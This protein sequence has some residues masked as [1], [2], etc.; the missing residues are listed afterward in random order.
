MALNMCEMETNREGTQSDS[1]RMLLAQLNRF[2][3]D[4]WSSLG[5]GGQH[6]G[7]K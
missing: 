3:E 6:R 5:R 1:T 4:N 2:L 7:Y